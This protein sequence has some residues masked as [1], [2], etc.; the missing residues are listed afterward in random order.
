[1]DHDNR[2]TRLASAGTSLGPLSYFS[3]L[4][5]DRL[6]CI[7]D[8]ESRSPLIARH[9]YS[10]SRIRNGSVA[11]THQVRS[12]A[13]VRARVE[14]HSPWCSVRLTLNCLIEL[15]TILRES[16]QVAEFLGCMAEKN[17]PIGLGKGA[18]YLTDKLIEKG[19]K[20]IGLEGVKKA[21]PIAIAGTLVA[22]RSEFVAYR[23]PAAHIGILPFEGPGRFGIGPNVTH[24]LTC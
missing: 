2:P 20:R 10:L 17:P 5:T 4:G 3:D 7:A 8:A 6:I 14:G 11:N 18:S 12:A 22:C 24:E 15:G 16:G 13:V 9:R 21:G 1:M 19:L 23:H